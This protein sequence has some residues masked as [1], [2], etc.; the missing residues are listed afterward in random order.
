MAFHELS[1]EDRYGA[2]GMAGDLAESKVAEVLKQMDRP[3]VPFGPRRVDT[4]RA[5][6]TTWPS[7]VR[8]APDFLGFARFIEVQGTN[9]D[10]VIVKEDKLQDLIF[11]NSLMPVW[12]GIYNMADDTVTFCDLP[13]MLWASSHP[14]SEKMTLDAGTRGEKEAYQIPLRVLMEKRYHN[15]FEAARVTSGK[16]KR[17]GDAG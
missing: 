13:A 3:V 10:T 17:K 9:G 5:Q 7:V 4:G 2:H 6:Q 8:H 1:G 15:A 16:R 12:F 14:E 11:W